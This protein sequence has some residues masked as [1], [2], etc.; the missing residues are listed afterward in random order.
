[1]VLRPFKL[2][3]DSSLQNDLAFTCREKKKEKKVSFLLWTLCTVRN[4]NVS[5]PI[6]QGHQKNL[7]MYCASS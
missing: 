7:K 6:Q 3:K 5:I 2:K 4:G 1:M